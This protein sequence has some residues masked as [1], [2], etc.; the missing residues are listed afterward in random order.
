MEL[1]KDGRLEEAVG[2]LNVWVQRLNEVYGA[3][4]VGWE[5]ADQRM[6]KACGEIALACQRI[7]GA[8]MAMRGDAAPPEFPMI[9]LDELEAEFRWTGE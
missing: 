8:L 6:Q 2:D 4:Q 5:S 9:D 3:W 7:E 1:R